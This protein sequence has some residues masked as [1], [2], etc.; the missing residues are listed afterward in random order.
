MILQRLRNGWQQFFFAPQSPLPIALFRILY[1]L[2]VS[3][4]LILLHGDWL[5]WYGGHSW[6]SMSTMTTI[7]PG[8]R[9]NLFGIIPQNDRWIGAFFWVFLVLAFMLIIGLWT[10]FSSAAVFLCL[11]SIQQRNLFILHGGDVFLRVAGFF[12]IFA[13]AGAALSIDRLIRIRR[14]REGATPPLS[15]PWAQ[16]MIQYQ[17]AFMYFVSVMW[18]L[19]GNTWRNGTAVDYVFH[20]HAV[21]RFP[22]PAWAL[23]PV[24]IKAETWL[25]LVIEFSLAVLIWFRPLRYPLLLVGLLFHL[26]LEYALNVPMFQWDILSAYV[27]FIDPDDLSRAWRAIFRR[28]P[29][30][31]REP[32]SI[33]E[34]T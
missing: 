34:T 6:I 1:G 16:R 17:L 32:E 27:L 11:A 23:L 8:V 9:L 15:A 4:T 7:E 13:P 18:K 30:R 2:C 29:V 31:S 10:R 22:L 26:C 28:A 20:L 24:M 33:T 12:L 21:T 3:A 19:K 14:G 25:T 5:E